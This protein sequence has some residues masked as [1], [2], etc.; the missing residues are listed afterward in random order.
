MK[1]LLLE[2]KLTEQ[3]AAKETLLKQL[4]QHPKI[5]SVRSFGLWAAIEF[6]SFDTCKRIIDGCMADG[7]FSD[8]FLFAGNCLRISPPLTISEAEIKKAVQV[9]L[10][11]VRK[12]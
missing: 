3:V 2:E 5:L 8:W 4:L 11:N 9:I 12:L 6:D 1:S 10:D 7:V